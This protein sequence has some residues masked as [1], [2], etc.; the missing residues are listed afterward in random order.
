MLWDALM[1]TGA[2]Q[3]DK[4]PP[5]EQQLLRTSDAKNLLLGLKTKIRADAS[6]SL[7]CC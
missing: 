2:H 4:A 5:V 6:R 7:K 1:K 3:G